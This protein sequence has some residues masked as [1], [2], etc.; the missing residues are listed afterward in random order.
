MDIHLSPD[1]EVRLAQ[2]AARDGRNTNDL[3]REVI[4]RFLDDETRFAEAVKLGV[5]AAEEGDF[6]SSDEVWANVERTLKS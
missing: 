4:A 5:V 6:V 3:V 2:L 1:Q